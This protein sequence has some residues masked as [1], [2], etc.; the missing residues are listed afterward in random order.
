M[1]LTRI[2]H[3]YKHELPRIRHE[4]STNK[5]LTAVLFISPPKVGGV[6]GGLKK[7]PPLT[8]F[9]PERL[10]SRMGLLSFS[11]GGTEGR[12]SLR[13]GFAVRACGTTNIII[14]YSRF[15]YGH[16][17]CNSWIIHV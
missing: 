15:I 17:R 1:N 7:A 2:N 6:R 12:R 14:G 4:L 5:S 11:H 8:P 3:K 10:L 16:L 13:S 9:L